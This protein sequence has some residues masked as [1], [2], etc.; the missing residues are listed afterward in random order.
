MNPHHICLTSLPTCFATILVIGHKDNRY[1]YSIGVFSDFHI[2]TISPTEAPCPV[3]PRVK[4]TTSFMSFQR[5]VDVNNY[6]GGPKELSPHGS[7][8]DS[9][10]FW[11]G[12][13]G[14]IG[15]RALTHHKAL[16]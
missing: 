1:E 11:F 13:S 10:V 12:H 8:L 15:T 14:I 9:L 6:A 4:Q 16:A 2:I 7:V 5:H 3:D